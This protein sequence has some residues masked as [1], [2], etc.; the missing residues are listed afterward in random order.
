[1]S[2]GLIPA[3]AALVLFQSASAEA[4]VRARIRRVGLFE[5]TQPWVRSGCTSFVDVE[6]ANLG[7]DVFEGEARVNQQDRDG[8]VVTCVEEVGL[9]PDGHWQLK[10]IYFT[11]GAGTPENTLQVRLFDRN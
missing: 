2:R 10:Q 6:F 3:L 5:G 7:S 4:Q 11:A 1:M 8:D 9:T